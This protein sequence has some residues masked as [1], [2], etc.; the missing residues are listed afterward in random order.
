MSRYDRLLDYYPIGERLSKN[1]DMDK[2]NK[3]SG[4][5]EYGLLMGDRLLAINEDPKNAFK[6]DLFGGSLD[7][8]S[9][10]P[11]NPKLYYKNF[12]DYMKFHG[13]SSGV[14]PSARNAYT[15]T[16]AKQDAI[17]RWLLS[18][19]PEPEFKKPKKKEPPRPAFSYDAYYEDPGQFQYLLDENRR[20]G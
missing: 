8:Y 6:K 5:K 18:E 7:I 2:V 11:K 9:G 15:E 13:R 3:N 17:N 10:A 4:L 14:K 16:R 1:I 12:E 20:R 19:E